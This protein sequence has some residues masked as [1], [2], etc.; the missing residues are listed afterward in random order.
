MRKRRGVFDMITYEFYRRE[1][2]RGDHLIGI[3]PERRASRER[4]TLESIMGWVKRVLG[5]TPIEPNDI[6]FVK[7]EI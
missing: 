5:D 6:Y 3:L 2:G 4:I 7:V 1:N